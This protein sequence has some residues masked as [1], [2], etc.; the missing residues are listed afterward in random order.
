MNLA[1]QPL[2]H[3]LMKACHIIAA[4]QCDTPHTDLASPAAR[5]AGPDL[6]R[7]AGTCC[8]SAHRALC[9]GRACGG[10]GA[11]G[12]P[13]G[14]ASKSG[15]GR[16]A[17]GGCGWRPPSSSAGASPEVL[18]LQQGG[19]AA[20]LAACS[21]SPEIILYVR[22]RTIQPNQPKRRADRRHMSL[23]SNDQHNWPLAN[24][25]SEDGIQTPAPHEQCV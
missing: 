25:K 8:P 22:R 3:V 11:C 24:R 14:A 17:R 20:K 23:T 16:G 21:T 18:Q 13:A 19:T 15:E 12:P 9:W 7:A 10:G 5:D 1:W 6:S 2:S 4:R